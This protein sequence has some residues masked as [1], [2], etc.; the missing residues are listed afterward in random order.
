MKS[1]QKQRARKRARRS[2]RARQ[3][4]S[5]GRAQATAVRRDAAEVRDR[6]Y[7]AGRQVQHAGQASAEN[8]GR[9][10][11]KLRL[12]GEA[13]VDLARGSAQLAATRAVEAADQARE[14]L[15]EATETARERV[16]DAV[17]KAQERV[18][19]TAVDIGRKAVQMTVQL[20]TL[21]VRVRQRARRGAEVVEEAGT[22]VV[23]SVLHTGS[24]VLDLA[25]DYVA[26]LTPRRRLTRAALERLLA[27]QLAWAR[28]GTEALDR[29]ASV[30]K[31]DAARMRIVRGKLQLVRQQELLTLVIRAAG[32]SVPADDRLPEVVPAAAPADG[33][34]RALAAALSVVEQMTASWQSIAEI[35]AAADDDTV[36][37]ALIRAAESAGAE[38]RE[39]AE[40]LR[41]RLVHETVESVLT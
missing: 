7:E 32:G 20:L 41:E 16:G 25:A 35:G 8:L 23:S 4:A 19:D 34:R 10:G 21:P 26:E 6:V 15:V 1:A 24:K 12:A 13:S 39:M 38:P 28:C 11:R 18:A 3:R 31:D 40:F 33:V 22:R 9:A 5:G 37:E 14:R 36:A 30:L 27:E 29:A 2:G 17:E